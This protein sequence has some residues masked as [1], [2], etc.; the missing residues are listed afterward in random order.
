MFN[1]DGMTLDG[2][3]QDTLIRELDRRGAEVLVASTMPFELVRSLETA[4]ESP[5]P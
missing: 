2:Y 5:E 3:H 4:L 1:A